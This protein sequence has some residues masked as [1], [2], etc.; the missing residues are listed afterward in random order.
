M[1]F[2]HVIAAIDPDDDLAHS[3]IDA[4]GDMASRDNAKL[5][6]VSVWPSLTV[7]SPPMA[8]EFA[9]GAT[10]VSE[11]QLEQHKEGRRQFEERLK[12]L[13]KSTTAPSN[14]VI[15]DGDAAAAITSYASSNGVDLIVTGSHQRSFF[16]RLLQGSASQN[17]IHDAPCAVLVVTKASVKSSGK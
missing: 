3:V 12:Q 14:V 17:L 7:T 2:S 16:D 9:A 1:K 6:L 11:A 15:V 5:D 13:A 4:A 8:A 10:T